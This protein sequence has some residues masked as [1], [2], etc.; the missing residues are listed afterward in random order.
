MH[1]RQDR[2][3]VHDDAFLQT[4]YLHS[5]VTADEGGRSDWRL[6]TVAELSGR[7]IEA[8]TKRSNEI[9]RGGIADVGGNFADGRIGLGQQLSCNDEALLTQPSDHR[10]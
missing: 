7:A 8:L 2:H 1:R 6:H 9:G 3:Q 10:H 4:P 5:E